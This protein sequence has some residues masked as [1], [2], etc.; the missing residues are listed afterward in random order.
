MSAHPELRDAI[1]KKKQVSI[2]YRSG[3]D[4]RDSASVLLHPLVLGKDRF[5]YEFVWGLLPD[6]GVY[7][8]FLTEK[9]T[10]VDPTNEPFVLLSDALYLN[11]AG[12]HWQIV[13]EGFD[14]GTHHFDGGYSLY[15]L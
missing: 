12:E 8:K 10:R 11:A 5:G 4:I 1:H 14:D 6:T 9:L 3:T 13:Y 15:D 7:Y 2:T